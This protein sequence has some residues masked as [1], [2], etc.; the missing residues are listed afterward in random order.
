MINHLLILC[1]LIETRSY[2]MLKIA[3]DCM[4]GDKG[5]SEI[6]HAVNDF[7][8]IHDDVEIT[9]FG[10]KEELI[11]L[12]NKCRIVDAREVIK[13]DDGP[14]E[15]MRK[16]NSSMYQAILTMKNEEMDAAIS[17]GST[18][19]FLST[20]TMVLKLL[21]GVKRAALVTA[22]P[23]L[24]K[25]KKVVLLDIGA[26][27]ENSS[28]ELVQF[29]LMGKLYAEAIYQIENPSVYLL[30]NGSEE[31]KGSPEGKIAYQTL[32]DNNFP[33]FKGNVEARYILNGEADVVVT[34]GY[35][36]N[37]L[38]KSTEGTA[39]MLSTLLKNAFTKNI[40][41]KIG[42]L[43]ARKGL[44]EMK[45]MMNYKN[46]GGAML[47]GVNGV[48]VKA[49]GSSDATSFLS[50]LKIAYSLAKAKVNEKIKEGI[51]NA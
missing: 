50:A 22:F 43:F 30:S 3:V 47:L 10:K 19:G 38:L 24:K 44:K 17:C 18:G 48:V 42:Y 28:E 31:H 1:I 39:K 45:E 21:P 20:A 40:F 41:T 8:A 16:K 37:I 33:N 6:L 29:A 9:L 46:T 32:K 7:L 2:I 15:V 26:N 49:H 4:G 27:N 13:M 35:T 23:T 12:E 14:L 34:D 25:D 36:G 51:I 5:S 11:S